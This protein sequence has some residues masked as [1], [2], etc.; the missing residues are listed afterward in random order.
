MVLGS[1][2]LVLRADDLEQWLDK[3]EP[4]RPASVFTDDVADTQHALQQVIESQ[5]QLA[6]VVTLSWQRVPALGNELGLLV[7]ALAK[8]TLELYPSLYGLTQTTHARWPESDLEVAAHEITRRIP[9]VLG[10]G[11]R[12]IL[13]ACRQGQVPNIKK[14]S[15]SD[16]VRQLAL[17]I[18][19]DRLILLIAVHDAEASKAS[20]R[21]LAQGAE[22]LA[23]N[24]RSRVVLV[25]PTALSKKNELDHVT[26]TACMCSA[27]VE[28]ETAGSLPLT[29][30]V[31]AKSKNSTATEAVV[32][33]SPVLGRP[34]PGS[35]AEQILYDQIC[36][37]AELAPLFRFNWQV[38]T[39]YHTSPIVDL[40]WE[41]GH[42]V[43]EIDGKEH[44]VLGQYIRDRR[45]DFELLMSGYRVIRFTRF[46]VLESPDQV[47]NDL[48]DAVRYLGKPE[49]QA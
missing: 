22:W 40:L 1:E 36:G 29:P 17:A 45:R 2:R 35:E 34:H 11:C 27:P 30:E 42:L 49:K 16:Q 20:L 7:T 46:K 26:Y 38:K 4:G 37:D 48:R 47:L 33:V 9:S 15:N 5:A 39:D 19:P 12:Q 24:T 6:R 25:L 31:P 43:V 32:S 18:Q 21:A 28:P 41:A 10:T 23:T 13:A 14:L 44:C 3:V 8:A